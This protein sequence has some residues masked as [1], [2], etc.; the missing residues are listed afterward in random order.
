MDRV[1]RTCVVGIGNLGRAL[2][3]HREFKLRGFHIVGAFDC[4]PSRSARS[5]PAWKSSA[6][7][8][9]R[10]RP[11]SWTSRSASSPLRPNAP[12]A[13]PIISWTRASR[14][15]STS[16]RRGSPSR[17]RDRGVCGLLPPLLRRGLQRDPESSRK[18]R[19]GANPRPTCR[20]THRHG[21]FRATASGRGRRGGVRRRRGGVAAWRCGG[22]VAAWRSW[23]RGGVAAWRRG[24]VAA[25]RRGGVAAWRSAGACR[26]Q[27]ARRPG[28]TSA[29]AGAAWAHTG[30]ASGQRGWK[31]QP[32]GGARG[33]GGS[34]PRRAARLRRVG[35]GTGTAR[36]RARVY[37]CSGAA[38]SS[39][40]G[41]SSM[42]RP[43]TSPP[44]GRTRGRPPTGRER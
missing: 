35:S 23:R 21:R 24:G 7:A 26:W 18:A 3:N 14:A 27:A 16:P 39:S 22:G 17:R 37:G 4:D 42:S 34:P 38:N 36:S 30:R 11:R 31:G 28:A 12:S 44:P 2:L 15:S 40:A 9:S 10:K 29:Q 41:A 32:A 13:P 25:W 43:G 20:T 19:P 8:A 5:S 33:L 1:W 6:R